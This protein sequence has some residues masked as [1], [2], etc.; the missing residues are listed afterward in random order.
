MLQHGATTNRLLQ[1]IEVNDTGNNDMNDLQGNARRVVLTNMNRSV[2]TEIIDQGYTQ[3]PVNVRQHEI[4]YSDEEDDIMVQPR[5]RQRLSWSDS[6][7]PIIDF[8]KYGNKIPKFDGSTTLC[9]GLIWRVF[10]AIQGYNRG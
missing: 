10:L 7:R 1:T 8:R 4:I 9:G 2:G 6:N 3:K 5:K